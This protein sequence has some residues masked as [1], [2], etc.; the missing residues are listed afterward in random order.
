MTVRKLTGFPFGSTLAGCVLF[1]D[2]DG[3]LC[4][5]TRQ[6]YDINTGELLRSSDAT[7]GITA[8]T[9]QTQA[10]GTALTKTYNQISVCANSNDAVTLPAAVLGRHCYVMNSGAQTCKVFPA[11]GD[12]CG[13]GVD[14]AVTQATTVNKHY[15]A[16]DGVTWKVI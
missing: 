13:G 5:D 16:I 7:I 8:S 2:A 1:V 14:T 12:D 11:V 10:G 4:L 15:Y 3:D 6:T 9:T